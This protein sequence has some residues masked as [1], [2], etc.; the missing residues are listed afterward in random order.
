M[1]CTHCDATLPLKA[2]FCPSCGGKV[3]SW[4]ELMFDEPVSRSLESA[5]ESGEW[6]SPPLRHNEEELRAR[7]IDCY[8][9]FSISKE[10]TEWLQD[11]GLPS[12]GTT[13]E[14]LARLRRHAGSLVLPAESFPRQTIYY[15]NKYDEDILSEIGQE[16]GIGSAGPKEVLLT[17]IYR[18][19]GLRE[20][21]LQPLS[22][23]ARQIITETFIPILGAFDHKKD[24]YLD[25]WDELSDVLDEDPTHLPVP[26]AYG[27]AIIAVLIPG[28]FQEAQGTL[29][30]NE[31]KERAGK[32][33]SQRTVHVVE[34]VTGQ[35]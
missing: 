16:L 10:L 17:R 9:N 23:D 24:Y 27:S 30:Q 7:L 5:D 3:K 32:R 14:K 11:L 31:L 12:S 6:T 8:L 29:L 34:P 22:E 26:P 33:S 1:D 28:F 13:Q 25:L 2:R 15:L 4:E 35:G 19:V 20:G 21:W 18:E